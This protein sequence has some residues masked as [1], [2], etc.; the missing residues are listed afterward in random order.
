[1]GEGVLHSGSFAQRGASACG[2]AL[3]SELGLARCVLTDRQASALAALGG[4]ALR[5]LWTSLTGTGWKLGVLAWD[6]QHGLAPR[7]GDLPVD[8]VEGAVVLRQAWPAWRPGAGHDGDAL[9]SPGRHAGTGHGAPIASKL[10][11]PWRLLHRLGQPL[12]R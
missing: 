6:H 5:S 4:G 1:M 2:F 12:S 3:G 8:A 7:T 9:R 11:Q 10:Q